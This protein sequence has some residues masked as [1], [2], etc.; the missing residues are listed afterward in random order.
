METTTKKED[1]LL[2]T[3]KYVPYKQSEAVT[4]AQDRVNQQMGSKPGAYQSTW[5][6]QMNDLMDRILNREKFSYDLNG[7]ALY[8]QYKNMYQLNG[9]KAMMDTMGQAQSMTGGYGNSYAQGVGQQAYQ[10][11]L[12]QLNDRVPELYQLALSQYNR[13]GEDMLN[14]YGLMADRENQDYGR[15]RDQLSDWNTELDRLLGRYDT[16]RSY[17]YGKWSDDR[18]FQY[19]QDRDAITDAQQKWAN[20]WA[21]FQSGQDTPEIRAIL[22]LPEAQVSSG[23]GGGDGGSG[24]GSGNGKG[25]G[26]GNINVADEY[27]AM[28]KN[29]ATSRDSDTYLKAAVNAGLI[30]MREATDLRDK[31]Y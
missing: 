16:E 17:D 31:R 1:E 30:S 10:G 7:D 22:G 28:K 20:A 8:Q 26:K 5:Q 12:Q 29:G 18:A 24:G 3:E 23:G 27:I 19:Q 25:N 6:K 4:Q 2:K 21:M 14:Q 15:Y 9:Q 13:Q 11:Y